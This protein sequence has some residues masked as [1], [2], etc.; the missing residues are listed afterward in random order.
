MVQQKM[1]VFE[2]Y[3]SFCLSLPLFRCPVMLVVGDQ[4]PY[5]DAAVSPHTI[6]NTF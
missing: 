6:R 2:V 4:A 1:Q 5:E 3:L